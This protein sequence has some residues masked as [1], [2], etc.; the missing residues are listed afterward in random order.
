ME[1]AISTLR[2]AGLGAE[3]YGSSPAGGSASAL[4]LPGSLH[5]L[6]ITWVV[7]IQVA[8]ILR[9]AAWGAR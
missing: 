1:V 2:D 7:A 9:Q 5:G 6:S 8:V 3:V 4:A